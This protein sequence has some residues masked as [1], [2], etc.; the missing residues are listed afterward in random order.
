MSGTATGR[1]RPA[2]NEQ[3]LPGRRADHEH[4]YQQGDIGR[5]CEAAAA[6]RHAEHGG[7]A[8]H[9]GHVQAS[10]LHEAVGVRRSRQERHGAGED[11]RTKGYCPWR[12]G[13][14]GGGLR[15]VPRR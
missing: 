9:E 7:V 10:K 3:H 5:A 13:A 8:A 6:Q 14:S 11:K 1:N 12:L 2:T 4:T 15:Q